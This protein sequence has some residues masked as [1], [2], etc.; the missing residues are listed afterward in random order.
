[1]AHKWADW[2]H[3]PYRLGGPQCWPTNGH[4]GHITLAA[5]GPQRFTTGNKISSGPQMGGL[6]T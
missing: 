3:N 1:M 2:L 5:R 4:I 6:A